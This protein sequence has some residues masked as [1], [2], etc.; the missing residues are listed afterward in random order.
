LDAPGTLDHVM[1]Q[2][3]ERCKIFR[4]ET[5]S[6]DFLRRVEGALILR[7][8][9]GEVSR[10]GHVYGESGRGGEVDPLAQRFLATLTNC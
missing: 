2:G 9:G 7:E 3:I 6:E 4:G 8:G 1:A 10:C 5:D